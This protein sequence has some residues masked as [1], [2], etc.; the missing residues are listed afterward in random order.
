LSKRLE[1][2]DSEIPDNELIE[3]VL[4]DIGV[5]YIPKRAIH[6]Q[7]YYM[8]Q[9]SGLY[10]G[11]NTSIQQFVERQRLNDLNCYLLY[12]PEE[13]PSNLDQDEKSLKFKIKPR[14]LNGMKRWLVR[15][16]TFLKCLMKNLFLILI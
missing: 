7:K 14:L 16:L 13:N 5:E 9:T 8:R 15:T 11:L 1:T 12:F 10:M 3:L 2:E 4:R 6:V